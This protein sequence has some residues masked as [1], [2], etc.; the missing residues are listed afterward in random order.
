MITKKKKLCLVEFHD[1]HCE[2]C[3]N[4]GNNKKYKLEELEIHK[5]NNQFGYE[6]FRVLMVVCKKHHD[7]LSSAHRIAIG[8]QK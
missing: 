4:Q 2:I 8:V 1:H 6:N 3:L 5:I 7:I